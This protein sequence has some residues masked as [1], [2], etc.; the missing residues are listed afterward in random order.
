LKVVET[1]L[2]RGVKAIR[3]YDP[4]ATE[5]AR[6]KWFNPEKNY[7]FERISYHLSAREAVSGSD[8]VYIST[9]WE[10]F[11]GLSR[12]IETTVAPPYLVMDGR[13]M[14]PDFDALVAR[15]YEY[16]PVGG[17]LLRPKRED[18]FLSAN[19]L[20]PVELSSVHAESAD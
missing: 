1:L 6:N 12:T 3:A 16:L 14:L 8:A 13:R 11:R 10:E 7:L 9:D 4:L 15:G 18:S 20:M 5:E 17:P 2:A 19:G